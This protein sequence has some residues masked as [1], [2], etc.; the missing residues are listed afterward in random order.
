MG[1]IN[2]FQGYLL[3]YPNKPRVQEMPVFYL[4]GH[5]Y[6][7]K[8][9]PFGLSTAPI[10]FTMV[11]KDIKRMAQNKGITIQQ[12]L[13]DW[14]VRATSRQTCLFPTETLVAVRK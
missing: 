10:K 6:P 4:Q 13:D 8:A 7:F 3:P 5:P 11:V 9:L 2:R 14:L 12:S 1:N